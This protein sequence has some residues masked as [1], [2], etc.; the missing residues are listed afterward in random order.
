MSLKWIQRVGRIKAV[1]GHSRRELMAD[2]HLRSP[3]ESRAARPD[4]M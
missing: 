4:Q 1:K 3:T 2:P